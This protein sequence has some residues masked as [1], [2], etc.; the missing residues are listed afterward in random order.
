MNLKNPQKAEYGEST[1]PNSELEEDRLVPELRGGTE[2]SLARTS[3]L[4]GNHYSQRRMP[5]RPRT[6]RRT[7]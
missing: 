1:I 2:Q 7:P 3:R 4:G 5:P 6:R